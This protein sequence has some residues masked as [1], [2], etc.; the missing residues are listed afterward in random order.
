MTQKFTTHFKRHRGPVTGVAAINNSN[1]VVTSGYDGAVALFDTESDEVTLLGYHDHLVNSI[2]TDTTGKFAASCSADYSIGIWDL[3]QRK[4]LLTLDGHTD[5]VEAFIFISEQKGASVSRD[6]SVILWDLSS[7]QIINKLLGHEKDV[8]SVQFYKNTLFTT[9]DDMTVRSWDMESGELKRMWGPFENETDTCAIDI[10]RER[11]IL[12]CDDGIIRIFDLNDGTPI[13]Q[14]DAHTSAIKK[15]TVD[16]T[17]GDILSAAYDQKIAIWNAQSF[18]CVRV[19]DPCIAKWER[20]FTWSCDGKR[21]YAGTFDGTVVIWDSEN[22]SLVKEIGITDTT[23]NACF[24]DI[25]CVGNRI[26]LVSDDGIVRVMNRVQDE[27]QLVLEEQPKERILT[28]ACALAP[29][30]KTALLGTHNQKIFIISI[31]GGDLYER[32]TLT[33][34]E[35]PINSIRVSHDSS[36]AFVAAYSGKVIAISMDDH[37]YNPIPIHGNAVKAI[38]LHPSMN[39]G[40]SCCAGGEIIKWDFDGNKLG[41]FEPHDSIVN[42]IAVSLDG[43]HLASVG[44]DFILN[45]HDFSSL[46]KIASIPIGNKSLK[47]VCFNG[48]GDVCVGDYW[49]NVYLVST[50]DFTHQMARIADNGVSAMVPSDNDQ[51]LAVSY[52]GSICI[53]DSSLAIVSREKIMEQR[54]DQVQNELI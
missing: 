24:N 40:V 38:E 37:D 21:V 54:L 7:G 2:F 3:E 13:S 26:L 11:L 27:L 6:C 43:K 18:E 53:F 4:R 23:G 19:L 41:E 36:K 33:P 50:N 5:D 52:D 42:D 46:A 44:R 35:G 8:L 47:S 30:G 48:N 14:I 17:N 51:M 15:V 25:S 9:G 31:E 12:G 10:D 1:L 45:I 32:G 49:G 22:G 39:I 16:P 34:G 20:S 28:N 29:D